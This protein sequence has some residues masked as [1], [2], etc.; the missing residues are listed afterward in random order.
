M[1]MKRKPIVLV[2]LDGWG[3][4][5]NPDHNA[6]MAANTPT[7]DALWREQPHGLLEASGHAVGVPDGQMGNSEVGHLHMGVG[8][9]MAQ[10]LLRINEAI[11]E[12]VFEQNPV[13]NQAIDE[14]LKANKALHIMGLSSAGGVHSHENHINAIIDLAKSKG[15]NKLYF[16]AILDG[17]DTPPQ[18]A[19]A[20][21][22]QTHC[23]VNS[24]IGRYYAM[25]RDTRWDR[26]EQAYNML[27]TGQALFQATDA[28]TALQMAYER[29][30]N[31]EFVKP[32][33]IETV[34][35][36]FQPI[37]D[38]DCVLFMN[39]RA[40]RARQLTQ[41]F[42]DKDFDGFT[43]NKVIALQSFVSLTEYAK[44]LDTAIAFPPLEITH[45]F[46]ACVSENGLKQLRITETEKYAHVT[47]FFNG[48]IETP[49]KGE[50]RKLITSAKVAYYDEKPE[51]SA[52]EITTDLVKAIHEQSHDTI[53]CNFANPDMVGH[54]GNFAATVKACE[55]IDNCLNKIVT[56]L[57]EVNGELLITAD[58]GN[59]EKMYNSDT[60]QI[61][62]AHTSNVVPVIYFGRPA[63]IREHGLL[64]DIA[65]TLLY[66][67]GLEKP[68]E[69]TGQSLVAFQ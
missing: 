30:E 33:L 36:P 11:A 41:A 55:T 7:W 52:N 24:I 15:C 12:G 65:P 59:A 44:S 58:H 38:G 39:F 22:L 62:T 68:A 42:I 46:G 2:I 69:M 29:G 10:S 27:T 48:G 6:I 21:L 45:S 20:S 18:S 17:R 28:K 57:K 13:L 32:T 16:H 9:P 26:I 63:Q 3:Y 43:R 40:D 61:H 53:I 49:F 4:N 54:T 64:Y 23:P 1:V 25:D 51:M 19:E 34:D 60:G 8:R 56:A 47:F 50:D 66:L 14:T 67:L 31:D 5:P 37:N 35:K